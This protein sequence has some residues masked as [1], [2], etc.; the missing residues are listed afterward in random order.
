MEK[1][2]DINTWFHYMSKNNFCENSDKKFIEYRK[3]WQ[4]W[5]KTFNIGDFPLFL[6]IEVTNACN[7]K[8]PFCVTTISG[9]KYEK[10]FITK[11]HVEKIIDEGANNGLYGIKFNIRGEPLL[12]KFIDYF[13]YY[14]K[15]NNMVDVYFNTN[16]VFLTDIMSNKLIDAGLDRISVS[17][18]GYT[19]E[20]YERNRVGSNYELVLK[21]VKELQKIKKRRNV[22]YPKVRVQTVKL[23]EI[24]MQQYKNFWESIADEVAYLDYKDMDIKKID[25]ISLWKCPQIWQRMAVLW[26]GDIF[27]CNHDD[28]CFLNLGNINNV[29]IKDSWNSLYVQRLR[30]IHRKGL[31]HTI[32]ACDGCYL[33]DAEISKINKGE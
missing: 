21:N 6:D 9:D 1:D 26:N 29:S 8:C 3:K 32:K 28:N 7:L 13:V 31:A 24:D 23:P 11:Y 25:I 4:S 16:A 2:K 18:E 33:R 17:F 30:D 27:P 15:Q 10:G 22:N 5:P 19:K 14:A 20:I 12:H